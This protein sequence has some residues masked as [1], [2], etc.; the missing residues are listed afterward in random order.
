M[1]DIITIG[2]VV[3][4][5]YFKG[6][7]L[8]MKDDRFY[9]ASG[10]KYQAETFHE[11]VGGSGANVAISL[12][13]LGFNTAVVAK[14][15]ENPFKQIILQKLMKKSVST[16]FL[17][18]TRDFYNISCILLTEA[19][20]KTVIHH[21]T[22]HAQLNLSA[23]TKEK[24]LGANAVYMGNLPDISLAEKIAL[25]SFFKSKDKPIY[26]NLG[27][28]DLEVGLNKIKP[29]ISLAQVLIVNAHE[30]RMLIGKKKEAI[31]LSQNYLKKLEQNNL[32]LVVT[33]GKSGSYAYTS[34]KVY[35]QEALKTHSV[36]DTT[37]AG[38]AYTAGFIGAYEHDHNI[39]AAMVEGSS[40][41]KKII[42]KLG[43]N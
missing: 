36:V 23:I 2:D 4:D 19:G 15:G 34:N 9:L 42:E 32:I 12:A 16:E 28:G 30:Y 5:L 21:A 10:G 40:R 43:A 22:P 14:V 35:F 29:L 1:Y 25:L 18:Y 6:A 33:D 20:E 17:L 8:T 38:D 31:N 39:E 26:L 41:A 3:I 13:N 37:G 24:L 27:R 11:G 7:S